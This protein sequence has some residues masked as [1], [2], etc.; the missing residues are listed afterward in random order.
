MFTPLLKPRGLHGGQQLL[1]GS[2]MPSILFCQIRGNSIGFSE[3]AQ[4]EP[5][6][7]FDSRQSRI[8]LLF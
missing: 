4:E 1:K 8:I 7:V 6:T 2:L 5:G 3:A